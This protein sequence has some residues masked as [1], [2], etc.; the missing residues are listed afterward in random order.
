MLRRLRVL[1]K[2]IQGGFGIDENL[3]KTRL[4]KNLISV[5][6]TEDYQLSR[7]DAAGEQ[8]N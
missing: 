5:V 1:P 2:P 6:L 8:Q 4:F 3:K 7:P